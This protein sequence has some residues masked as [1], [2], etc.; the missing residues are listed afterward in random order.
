MLEQLH[1]VEVEGLAP[2]ELAAGLKFLRATVDLLELEFARWLAAFDNRQ[3]F[4]EL[5]EHS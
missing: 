3:T 5:G 1:A 4:Y 2:V